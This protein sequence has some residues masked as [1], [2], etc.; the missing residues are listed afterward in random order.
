M[1]RNLPKP[2]PP[3]DPGTQPGCGQTLRR[4]PRGTGKTALLQALAT[5]AGVSVE[6][7]VQRFKLF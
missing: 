4:G 7:L 5:L 3:I 6:A 2:T 1:N